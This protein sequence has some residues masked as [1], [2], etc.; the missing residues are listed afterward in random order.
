[1]KLTVTQHA[2]D[3]FTRF[4]EDAYQG[5]VGQP[6]TVNTPRGPVPGKLVSVV[7]GEDGYSV[8]LTFDVPELQLVWDSLGVRDDT[9]LTA[10]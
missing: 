5:S 6:L 7:V 1:M 3:E 10:A 2:P 8:E 4:A 9:P